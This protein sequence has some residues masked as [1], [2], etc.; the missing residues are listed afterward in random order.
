MK[1]LLLSR[2]ASLDMPRLRLDTRVSEA[3][4][5]M[6]FRSFLAVVIEDPQGAGEAAFGVGDIRFFLCNAPARVSDGDSARSVSCGEG[7]WLSKKFRSPN[8]ASSRLDPSKGDS[9]TSVC[10][11]PRIGVF[12][13]ISGSLGDNMASSSISNIKSLVD[14]LDFRTGLLATC[15]ISFAGVALVFD[16]DGGP[17]VFSLPVGRVS[18]RSIRDLSFIESILRCLSRSAKA[19]SS[20]YL[21]KI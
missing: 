14:C 16:A 5:M 19:T 18:T 7:I 2:R 8:D 15:G 4:A 1:L 21:S 13:F 9:T 3:S 17:G 12:P 6:S 11:D 20:G 10:L